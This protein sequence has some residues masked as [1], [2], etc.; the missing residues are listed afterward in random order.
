[1]PLP[2]PHCVNPDNDQDDLL[3]AVLGLEEEL[4]AAVANLH[5]RLQSLRSSGSLAQTTSQPCSSTAKDDG[6]L[7]L[8]HDQLIVEVFSGDKAKIVPDT[9]TSSS[10]P[11]EPDVLI[12][13]RA[14]TN[15]G[16]KPE[17]NLRP[18]KAASAESAGDELRLTAKWMELSMHRN[19]FSGLTAAEIKRSTEKLKAHLGGSGG[20]RV[21]VR[22]AIQVKAPH[23]ALNPHST[24]RLV[25]DVMG[26]FLMV[27]DCFLLPISLAWEAQMGTQD[28]GAVCL[29]V[30]FWFAFLY[31]M[32]DVGMNF[33]TGF[34]DRG[35]LVS[36]HVAIAKHYLRTWLI[37]DISLVLLDIAVVSLES[38][39]GDLSD[40]RVI[41]FVRFMRILRLLRVLKVTRIG[42]LIEESAA[43]AGRRWIIMFSAVLQ[44]GMVMMI[45]AHFLTCTWIWVGRNTTDSWLDRAGASNI[46]GWTQYLHA[47]RWVMNSPAPA[48]I[49]P[50]SSGERLT[51]VFL[52]LCFIFIMGSAI[53]KIS[54]TLAELRA[55]NEERQR[56]RRGIRLYLTTQHVGF[57]LI[58]RIMRFVDYKLERPSLA[59]MDHSLMSPTLTMELYVNQ[60][61]GVLLEHPIFALTHDAFPEMFS[62]LCSAFKKHVFEKHESAFLAGTRSVAMHMT[63][64][65]TLAISG[66]ELVACLRD[67]PI[68]SVMFC[69][70]AKDFV[71]S[72]KR[73]P[74]GGTHEQKIEVSKKC[75]MNTMHYR[76]LHPNPKTQLTNVRILPVVDECHE[77]GHATDFQRN[78]SE[79][80]LNEYKQNQDHLEVSE[81]KSSHTHTF[82]DNLSDCSSGMSL[83][84]FTLELLAEGAELDCKKLPSLLQSHLLELHKSFGTHVLFDQR[85]ERDR[86]ESAC[87]SVIALVTNRYDL[88]TQ[89]QD[90]KVKLLP[91]QWENLQQIVAWSEVTAEHLEAVLVLLAIRGLGK[92]ATILQQVPASSQRPEKAVLHLMDLAGNVVP[93]VV[94]LGVSARRFV[95]DA[96]GLHELFNFAQMLQGENVPANI[97]Q[98]QEFVSKKGKQVL[99]FYILFLLGFMSGLAG[100]EGSRFMNAKNAQSTIS[101]IQKLLH[102]LD[103]T[104]NAI[105]W[106]YLSDRAQQLKL[107]WE[108]ADDLVLVR[109]ACLARVQD[110]QSYLALWAAWDALDT[111]EKNSLRDHFLADGIHSKAFLLEF[112]PDCVGNSKA[113]A[114]IG[115]TTLFLVLVDLLHN[116]HIASRTVPELGQA[117]IIRVDL[118]EMAQFISAVHNRFVFQT[119][120]S[121]CRLI[122]DIA[123]N[124][125]RFEMTGSNWSRINDPDSDMTILSY[126]LHQL[127]QR[128]HVME[129]SLRRGVLD[130]SVP[131]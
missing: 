88:F 104:P 100:G 21:S 84:N 58:S 13:H 5:T 41:R 69:E 57:E 33:H 39:A 90:P 25:W 92:N 3:A 11:S 97:A 29:L 54:E 120:I 30:A 96:L 27:V 28:A 68:C 108:T 4:K 61:Q 123:A 93:S 129:E 95:E 75:C 118:S 44:T 7:L 16:G 53:S 38:V 42:S 37:F 101:G 62:S 109:M 98:L 121:R 99:Q 60:R 15:Q 122:P 111:S 1:M 52:N 81:T 49:N 125:I 80:T 67:S 45:A 20:R 36:S 6:K 106:G 89:P 117:K 35:R 64:A 128:Q 63:F 78:T 71:N 55:M 114:V 40:F 102:V 73:L 26:L 51:D 34:Y 10:L 12:A 46:S 2:P 94:H 19:Q 105:Y 87:I 70:Y 8:Q 56:R 72:S 17:S 130:K 112:L 59:G 131:P 9:P 76:A 126:S 116:L 86:G 107:P 113:N 32:C 14:Q 119:C 24:E 43:Q 115:I 65:E 110:E 79:E 74:V 91:E 127:M 31:W 103:S 48:P 23:S 66:D 124:R 82:T 50:D 18:I 77:E 47:M 85:L 83:A 22:Q